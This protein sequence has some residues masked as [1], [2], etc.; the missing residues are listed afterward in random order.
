MRG[1]L[2]NSCRRWRTGN[3]SDDAT[4]PRSGPIRHTGIS[5]GN[6]RDAPGHNSSG[7]KHHAQKCGAVAC[8]AGGWLRQGRQQPYR[9]PCETFLTHVARKV[10]LHVSLNLRHQLAMILH[11]GQSLV[12]CRGVHLPGMRFKP[13]NNKP[14]SPG[15]A[16]APARWRWCREVVEGP[17]GASAGRTDGHGQAALHRAG[18][19]CR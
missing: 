9:A 10:Q 15:P 6:G 12:V 1:G 18:P 2:F 3:Q 14:A 4:L 7:S 11:H 8:S 5:V 17:R 19:C 16:P 13:V